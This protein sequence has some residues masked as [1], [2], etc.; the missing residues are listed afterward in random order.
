MAFIGLLVA[1]LFLVGLLLGFLALLIGIIVDIIWMVRARK[2]KK[3]NL[4]VRFLAVFFS[5]AGV[6]SFVIPL[7]VIMVIGKM[8]QA[9][10]QKSYDEIQ[11]KVFVTDDDKWSEHFTFDG[12]EFVRVEFIRDYKGT[13]HEEYVGALVY[14]EQRYHKI[15][16]IQNQN[17]YNIYVLEDTDLIFCPESQVDEIKD[18]YEDDA[19][20]ITT[21]QSFSQDKPGEQEIEFDR[22]IL[23]EIRGYYQTRD[24]DYAGDYDEQDRNFYIT[25]KSVDGLYYEDLSLAQIGDKLVLQSTSSGGHVRGITLDENMA[26]Y[27]FEQVGDFLTEH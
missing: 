5:L 10:S 14:G 11:N 4:F 7:V 21:V 8:G 1:N 3:T 23:Q 20:L 15:I 6:C 26:E 2:K 9:S 27:V 12:Q 24:C 13:E 25:I 16:P 22:H 17:H 18:F 19:E